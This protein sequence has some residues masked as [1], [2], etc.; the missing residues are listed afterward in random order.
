M[1]V[2]GWMESM[3]RQQGKLPQERSAKEVQRAVHH[4]E[5][6]KRHMHTLEL[7]NDDLRTELASMQSLASNASSTLQKQ[8]EALEAF[9]S[10][11]PISNVDSTDC[12]DGGPLTGGPDLQPA[13]GA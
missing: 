9:Y 4:F 10:K 5:S 3:Y 11:A 2:K 13:T 1:G 7:E 12:S 6:Q 8:R